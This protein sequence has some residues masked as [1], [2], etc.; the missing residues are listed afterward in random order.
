MF[1]STVSMILQL[2]Q[3][4]LIVSEFR[5]FTKPPEKV[6][7]FKGLSRIAR[8]G[9]PDRFQIKTVQIKKHRLS[10]TFNLV[11]GLQKDVRAVCHNAPPEAF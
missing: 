10:L 11:R 9:W 6:D 5:T 1:A 2:F 8:P 4:A 3:I 7:H